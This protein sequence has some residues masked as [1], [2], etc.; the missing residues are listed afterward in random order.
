MNKN[1]KFTA[2]LFALLFTVFTANV[3]K[4]QDDSTDY[5]I[6]VFE[7]T[8]TKKGVETSDANPQKQRI[9]ISNIVELPNNSMNDRA[10]FRDGYKVADEYF[11]S[12][13]SNPLIFGTFCVE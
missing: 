13:I 7:T 10:V 6:V 3:V 12:N 5:A 1:Y 4:A 9:Y 8:V 11:I 2:V